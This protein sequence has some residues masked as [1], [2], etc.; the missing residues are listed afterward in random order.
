M[1]SKIFNETFPVK[2]IEFAKNMLN[3]DETSRGHEAIALYENLA[4]FEEEKELLFSII[5]K[6]LLGGKPQQISEE[7]EEISHGISS[8]VTGKGEKVTDIPRPDKKVAISFNPTIIKGLIAK[9]EPRKKLFTKR[10]MMKRKYW[11]LALES[12]SSQRY[13]DSAKEYFKQI[14]FLITNGH[15]DYVPIALVMGIISLIKI[16]K[17]AD[18]KRKL[19]K[20]TMDLGTAQ[21]VMKKLPEFSLLKKLLLAKESNNEIISS[22]ILEGIIMNY[23][24]FDIEK[25]LLINLSGKE[26]STR[27]SEAQT[28]EKI[29]KGHSTLLLNQQIAN[30]KQSLGDIKSSSEKLLKKRVAMRRIYYKD[31][32]EKLKAGDYM[33]ASELYK[34]VAIRITQRNDYDIAGML[35]LLGAGCL[36]LKNSPI[37]EIQKYMDEFLDS[38][39]F[40]KKVLDESFGIKL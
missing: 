31:I 32:L 8:T 15:D 30:L 36:V 10:K 19:E 2:V 12:L 18:G 4:L 3:F 24:L 34:S 25:S 39:G 40:T 9:L 37:D 13:S 17:I 27:I 21:D 38:L 6:E 33:K 11:D 16:K 35:I 7:H 28:K 29:Q 1:S 20:I 5:G 22:Q 26:V 14:K 23:P